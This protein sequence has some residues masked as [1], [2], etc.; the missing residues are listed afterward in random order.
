M[1]KHPNKVTILADYLEKVRQLWHDFMFTSS[2]DD[3]PLLAS[4]LRSNLIPNSQSVEALRYILKKGTVSIP[5][6]IDNR[7]LEENGLYDNLEF[8]LTDMDMFSDFDWANKCKAL[9]IKFISEHP[10]SESLAEAIYSNFNSEYYAWDMGSYL[11]NLFRTNSLKKQEYLTIA[12]A[13]SNI[14]KPSKIQSL[15]T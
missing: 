10:I 13:N 15:Y 12:N 2:E 14:G 5:N 3:F 7:T 11:D 4:M 1:R 8:L 6:D 9:I